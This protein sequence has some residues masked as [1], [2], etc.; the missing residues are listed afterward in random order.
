MRMRIQPLK[1]VALGLLFVSVLGC[2]STSSSSTSN[3]GAQDQKIAGE[4][5]PEASIPCF[6]GA[7]Y[8]KVVSSYDT[9][10]GI[11]GVVVLGHPSTDPNRLDSQRNNLPLDNFS[12]YMGGNAGGHYEVDA[13]MTWT[14]SVDKA[15]GKTSAQRIAWRPFWRTKVWN[16]PPNVEHYT[17]HPGDTIQMSVVM[18]AP[19]KLR[20][21][22]ADAGKHPKKRFEVDFD[23]EG[24]TPDAKRQFKRV[25][26]ID[27]VRNEGKP[28][29][30]TT[31]KVTGSE[32][33]YTTLHR[34]DLQVPMTPARLTDMR[35]PDAQYIVVTPTANIQQ[36]GE[37]IDIVGKQ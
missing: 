15:T 32:W 26:A 20:M 36:G 16:N 25:N 33:L 10:T 17:W 37:R 35:C 29:Q 12:I 28:A 8:R 6:P 9:W 4:I 31:A 14:F 24:F 30:A 11:T 13:G 5:P 18:V 22:I 3:G 19:Q 23:A 27:Q 7:Y 34:G 21:V 2:K 1:K